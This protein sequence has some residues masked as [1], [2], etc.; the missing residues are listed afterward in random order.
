MKIGVGFPY[1][2]IGD[3]PGLYRAYALHA[4]GLGF[5]HL[6]FV[7]HVL[8]SE[9]ARRDPPLTGPY[10]EESIFHEPL[11]L[12]G[13]LAAQTQRIELVTAILILA[14]R[15]AVL[16]AKQAAELQL[17]SRG[18]LRL[19]VGTGWNYLEY[20]SMGVPYA[21]RGRRLEEQVDVMRRLWTEPLLDY[22][23]EF[24]RIS[25]S[26]QRPLLGAP[27]PIWFGGFSN[28]A[29][30][31]CAR[32]GDGFTFMRMTSLSLAAIE[33]IRR[34]AAELGRDPEALGFET[35]LGEQWPIRIKGSDTTLGDALEQWRVA[36]GTHATVM[37]PGE[38]KELL[39]S[40]DRIAKDVGSLLQ[41]T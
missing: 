41:E 31:R 13:W 5:A 3:D 35:I 24:H 37:V 10:T 20:E 4:E 19:G 8:G 36:G 28:A 29:Q 2:T 21:Q 30:D 18:R 12:M 32:I 34:H 11:T 9:H 22:K 27:V 25:R 17:L 23:G 40:L 14:Q 1:Q 38:G 26:G 15:Q 6:A 39:G 7:D 16:V 33:R